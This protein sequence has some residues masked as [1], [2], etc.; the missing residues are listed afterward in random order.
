MTCT[1]RWLK[2]FQAAFTNFEKYILRAYQV[3]GNTNKILQKMKIL[4]KLRKLLIAYK[5]TYKSFNLS[6]IFK[7]AGNCALD[8]LERWIA[9][10]FSMRLEFVLLHWKEKA[11]VFETGKVL[12]ASNLW[13]S[14]N[15]CIPLQSLDTY[16]SHIR[17]NS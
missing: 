2:R 5:S 17:L 14:R 15:T 13:S 1:V 9:I 4:Q 16:P 10:Q 11:E 7:T 8:D 6:C 12:C 3:F